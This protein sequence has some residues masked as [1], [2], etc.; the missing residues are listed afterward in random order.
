MYLWILPILMQYI[1][2]PWCLIFNETPPPMPEVDSGDEEYLPT[3]DLDDPVWSEEPVPDSQEYLCIHQIPRP[4]TPPLQPNQVEMPPSKN[5][6]QPDPYN[7]I[8]WRSPRRAR[9]HGYRHLRRHTR[10]Y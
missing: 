2:Q 7:L 4:A 6:Q 5:N 8:K 9:T 1:F 3:V 10:P